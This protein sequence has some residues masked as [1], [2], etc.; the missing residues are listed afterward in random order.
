MGT[1]ER[2]L[3]HWRYSDIGIPLPSCAFC[4]LVDMKGA[5]CTFHLAPTTHYLSDTSEVRVCVI[6][7]QD[8]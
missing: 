1:R 2:P 4:F 8:L 7:G 6:V 5:V 3:G